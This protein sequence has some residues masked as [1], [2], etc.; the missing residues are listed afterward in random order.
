MSKDRDEI[1]YLKDLHYNVRHML[2]QKE[3]DKLNRKMKDIRF[4]HDPNKSKMI[5]V[6]TRPLVNFDPILEERYLLYQSFMEDC[7]LVHYKMPIF[8]NQDNE[9]PD[10]YKPKNK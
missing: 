1:E 5:L 8:L 6:L 10:K 2:D 3:Y 9:V 4:T 7:G